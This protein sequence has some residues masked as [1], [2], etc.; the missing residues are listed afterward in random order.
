MTDLEQ[1]KW[2]FDGAK[3]PSNFKSELTNAVE[4]LPKTGDLPLTDEIA[5]KFGYPDKFELESA[6][7]ENF[8]EIF[9]LVD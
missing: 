5:A 4:N 2:I 9:I 1:I 7:I 3:S 6:I 8:D